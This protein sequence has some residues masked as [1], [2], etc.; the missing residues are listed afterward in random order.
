MELIDT[1]AHLTFKQF[2]Q[3]LD[4]YLLRSK[5]ASVKSWITIATTP[6]EVPLVIELIESHDNMYAGLGFHP[7]DAKSITDDDLAMLKETA[8][9]RKVVAI[10]ETGLDF[11]YD[12]SP[13][14]TQKQIFRKHLDI[15][16]ELD[17]PVII[18]T[19]EA[20]D[21][22]MEILDE[23]AGKLKRVVIHCYSG[24]IGQTKLVL[25]KGYYISFTGIVT[26]KKTDDVRTAAKMVPMDR[27]MIET[28]CPFISPEPV[29]GKKPCE[30]AFLKH[31]AAKIAEVKGMS[32]E[33][34]ADQV[35]ATSK[36]FFELPH[37]TPSG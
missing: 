20:F 15:A 16:A 18:H 19:R 26:F 1:H 5:E 23:F 12:H 27:L 7:H 14:E 37:L 30:P 29:R 10:G 35:T 25:G 36:E 32:L 4:R 21:E 6:A 34:F 2:R 8:K 13:R 11:F 22:S 31:I 24:S 28:D 3:D 17:M 9:H 33:D